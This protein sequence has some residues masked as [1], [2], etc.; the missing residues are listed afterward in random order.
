MRLFVVLLSITLLAVAPVLAELSTATGG[1]LREV[2]I[3]PQASEVAAAANDRVG[4]RD[5]TVAS[6]DELA[7]RQK[8]KADIM[9]FVG[10]RGFVRAYRQDPAT[11]LPPTDRFD[12]NYLTEEE[13]ALIRPALRR[14]GDELYLRS[15]Q[16]GTPK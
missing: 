10:T 3:D 6:L 5:G 1:Y 4:L 7:R 14:A 2:G 9:R 12:A 11:R 13:R 15:L 8:P 16:Q